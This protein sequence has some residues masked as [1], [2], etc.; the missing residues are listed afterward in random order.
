MI[1][2]A[3]LK[4]KGFDYENIT[5]VLL[6]NKNVSQIHGLVCP[7]ILQ[8]LDLMAHIECASA[9][10][11]AREKL[12][13]HPV[14][15]LKHQPALIHS[16]NYLWTCTVTVIACTALSISILCAALVLF[17]FLDQAWLLSDQ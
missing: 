1:S 3:F 13:S 14:V 11:K 15:S 6:S 5:G 17:L 8:D 12:Y 16:Y 4:L 9:E 2:Q 7:P 10:P